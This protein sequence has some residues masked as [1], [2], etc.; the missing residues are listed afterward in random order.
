MG[1]TLTGTTPQ[2]TYDSLIKVTNNGPLSSTARYLSDGLGND[3]ILALSTSAVGI[4]Y[5]SPAR[6]L[7]IVSNSPQVRISD[8]AAPTTNFWEIQ[9]AF[10]NTNQDFF[11]SNQ[12]GTALTINASRNVGIG[13]SAPQNRLSVQTSA[14][15]A[16]QFTTS[17]A[18]PTTTRISIGGFAGLAPEAAG[19]AAI[20]AAVNH[21]SNSE[22]ALVF[23]TNTGSGLTEKGRFLAGGGLTFN[24]DTAAANA[25]DD[26]EEG[27]FTPA[28]R[29]SSTAGTATYSQQN[30]IYT[31]I[32]RMVQFEIYVNWSGGT[33]TGNLQISGL[34]F[35]SANS[36]TFS[37]ASISYFNNIALAASGNVPLS[38]VE[39]SSTVLAFLEMPSG[40][41][42]NANVAYSAAGGIQIAG[43][44]SV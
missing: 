10:A 33:G 2:D 24:G 15:Y 9:S 35:T 18:T 41:G 21:G 27:T 26:Y 38:Y 11:I 36:N 30:G 23:Y 16:A 20:G 40:G 19:D 25:L 13:T 22:S 34:P 7:H 37:S 5:T 44:Y 6:A 43:T 12:G 42:V 8:T 31:K 4:N 17:I 28:I 29:G 1:T 14:V 39:N 32:G 3:S